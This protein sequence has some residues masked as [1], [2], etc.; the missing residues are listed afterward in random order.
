MSTTER[1]SGILKKAYQRFVALGGTPGEIARGFALGLFIGMS[2]YMMCHTVTALF[3]APL[4]KGNKLAAAAGV[5]ITNP[6]T[7]PFFYAITFK[8]G[9]MM[10]PETSS[11]VALPGSFSVDA[12]MAL[13]KSGPE[14]IWILTIG[15]VVT[16]IP[17]ALAGYLLA[18][19]LTLIY[20]RGRR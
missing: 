18:Y 2:P 11:R 3:V 17:V 10:M 8:V 20:R 7:A 5:F 16:G 6:L 1:Y 12:L 13:V 15:G 4:M 9:A 14:I 19:R